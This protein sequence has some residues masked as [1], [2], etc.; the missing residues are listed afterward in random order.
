MFLQIGWIKPMVKLD[1]FPFDYIKT[2]SIKDYKKNYL[3]TKLHFRNLYN[4]ERF[5]FDDEF[6]KKF[7]K[8]GFS[9][10]PTEYIAEGIDAS[11]S[12][13]FPPLKKISYS[14]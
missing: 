5:S 4:Q 6:E 13:N 1:I 8:L 3:G 10:T 9:Y 14:L 2:E 12:D 7:N 11:F